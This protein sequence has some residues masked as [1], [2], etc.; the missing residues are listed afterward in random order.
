MN[1]KLLEN[2]VNKTSLKKVVLSDP[3]DPVDKIVV[4]DVAATNHGYQVPGGQKILQI[5]CRYL[6]PHRIE[7]KELEKLYADGVGSLIVTGYNVGDNMAIYRF[8]ADQKKVAAVIRI[9]VIKSSGAPLSG[10]CE[11]K[12]VLH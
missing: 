2:Q 1:L 8:V 3:E 10:G 7:Y 9:E 12:T 6:N 4:S 5:W 11:A